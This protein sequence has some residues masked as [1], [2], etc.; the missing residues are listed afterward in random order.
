[1]P[2]RTLVLHWKEIRISTLTEVWKKSIPT[3]IDNFK[4]FKT[5]V[6]EQRV[7]FDLEPN[8]GKDAVKIVEIATKHLEY[9]INL[10]V[11]AVAGFERIDFNFES[12]STVSKMSSNSIV[13]YREIVCKRKSQS[14]WQTSLLSYFKKLSQLLP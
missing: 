5:S 14:T 11:K 6:D 7:V 12:I 3:L 8:S 10:I 4:R 9:Y 2:L 1:M 13:C